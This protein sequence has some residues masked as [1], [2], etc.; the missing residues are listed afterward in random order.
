MSL[1]SGTGSAGTGAVCISGAI[2]NQSNSAFG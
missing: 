1:E 2:Y